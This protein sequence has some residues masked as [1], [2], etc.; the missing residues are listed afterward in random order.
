M[1]RFV[2]GRPCLDFVGTM[3][4][5]RTSAVEQLDTDERL[6]AWL[7]EADIVD[8]A[9]G[10]GAGERAQAIALR[11]C[12]H[13]SVRSRLDGHRLAANDVA[14]INASC[15]MS[16]DP[17]LDR[18]GVRTATGTIAQALGSIARDAVDL[19]GAMPE[20]TVRE[21]AGETCTRLFVDSSRARNRRWCGMDEC[22]N[23]AKVRRF[24]GR[25]DGAVGPNDR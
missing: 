8:L 16:V 5:R 4:W 6:A 7:V 14:S 21:C 2:S 12:V 15:V 22:G 24:R 11:E 10:V 20:S 3:K 17:C 9:P 19:I 18:D 13:R 1:F 23:Q 25:P